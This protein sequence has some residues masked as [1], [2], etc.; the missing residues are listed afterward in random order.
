MIAERAGGLGRL[1]FCLGGGWLL[2]GSASSG[3][4]QES[5]RVDHQGVAAADGH[6]AVCRKAR[7]GIVRVP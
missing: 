6:R 3:V 7:S 1:L 4:I 2:A 5:K